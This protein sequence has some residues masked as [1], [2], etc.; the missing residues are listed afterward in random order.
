MKLFHTEKMYVPAFSI[1][2]I[3]A[4]LLLTISIS[5]Y[6][7]LHTEKIKQMDHLLRQGTM[8]IKVLEASER[9]GMLMPMWGEDEFE[10]LIIEIGKL[11]DVEYIYLVNTK[12]DIGHHS[13]ENLKEVIVSWN[14]SFKNESE[15]LSRI[16]KQY[17]DGDKN[18][19]EIALRDCRSG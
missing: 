8:L 18:I 3:A 10:K 2:G 19:F 6:K 12:G 14:P 17:Q 15:T 16:S 13:N 5:T 11:E 1:V 7:N 4:L 9:A